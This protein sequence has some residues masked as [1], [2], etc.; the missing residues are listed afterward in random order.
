[1]SSNQTVLH[2]NKSDSSFSS[3]SGGKGAKSGFSSSGIILVTAL[4][5]SAS[6]RAQF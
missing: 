1:M 3:N 2:P 6:L 4:T 5:A